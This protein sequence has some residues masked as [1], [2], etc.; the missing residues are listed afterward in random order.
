MKLGLLADIHEHVGHLRRALDQFQ[1]E[2]VEQVVVLGDLFEM[3]TCIDE[4]CRLLEE[5][6]AV[7][8]WGNH[9]FG[10]CSNPKADAF[11]AY[12]P[13]VIKYVSSLRPRLDVADCHFTHVEPWLN[14]DNMLDLWYFEG[15]PDDPAKLG[16][17]FAASPQRIFFTGHFHQWLLARPSGIQPWQG[18]VPIRLNDG[19]YF[20]VI[21]AL[22]DGCYAT[23]DTENFELAPFSSA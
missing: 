3:G 18:D 22:C 6:G 1:R 23:F 10:L 19:R 21:G 8:V 5:A 7:G 20:V 2:K 11:R 12:D 16:R 15:P 4:T 13:A 9:D 14:P 17:I